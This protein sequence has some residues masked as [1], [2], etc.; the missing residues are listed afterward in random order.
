VLDLGADEPAHNR[1]VERAG[2]DAH[3]RV[4]DKPDAR[5][6]EP[7]FGLR[8]G[9]EILHLPKRAFAV[10]LGDQVLVRYVQPIERPV[11]H[12]ECDVGA[13]RREQPVAHHHRH[14]PVQKR[15]PRFRHDRHRRRAEHER[16]VEEDDPVDVVLD[17]RP[18]RLERAFV[19]GDRFRDFEHRD[20]AA[21]E[22][23][24]RI[25]P[26][27][28]GD[29]IG[30]V[31]VAD[32]HKAKH[33]TPPDSFLERAYNKVRP[34]YNARREFCVPDTNRALICTKFRDCD[35]CFFQM[36]RGSGC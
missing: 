25:L 30:V 16:A 9:C 24:K 15:Q 22:I 17:H 3:R 18:R 33:A 36:F 31:R 7:L 34:K 32:I 10:R 23:F 35:D 1:V 4:A 29:R 6:P 20:A 11:E 14:A 13:G 28:H 8:R 12:R 19:V 27:L 5:A 2:V 26:E 21:S